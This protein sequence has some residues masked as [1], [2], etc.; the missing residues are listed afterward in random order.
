MIEK[1]QEP[2]AFSHLRKCSKTIGAP[3]LEAA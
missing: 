1:V 3:D 2:L